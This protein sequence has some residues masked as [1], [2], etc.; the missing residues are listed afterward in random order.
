[1]VKT[2]KTRTDNRNSA[3]AATKNF[4]AKNMNEFTRLQCEDIS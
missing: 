4:G 3:A 1:M 2:S